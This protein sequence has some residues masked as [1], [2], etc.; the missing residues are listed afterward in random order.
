MAIE[1]LYESGARWISNKYEEKGTSILDR[2]DQSQFFQQNPDSNDLEQSV[3]V[4]PPGSMGRHQTKGEPSRTRMDI[5]QK[6]PRSSV[7]NTLLGV[8]REW[9]PFAC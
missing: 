2:S 4:S 5:I 3:I 7:H 6:T 9:L 1:V 8:S